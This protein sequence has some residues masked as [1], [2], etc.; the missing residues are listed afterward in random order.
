MEE[1]LTHLGKGSPLFSHD[2]IHDSQ[3]HLAAP[4][5]FY[6]Q[7]RRQ[8]ALSVRS[9]ISFSLVKVV[10]DK[11]S[12]EG[13]SATIGAEDILRFS[14]ELKSLTRTEDCIGRLGINECLIIISDGKSAA[15]RLISRLLTAQS[16]SVNHTLRISISAVTSHSGENGL[17]LLNRLDLQPLSTH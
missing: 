6:E 3:T 4:S 16:L 10:F 7:L 11:S 5:F 15:E 14:C 2:G 13:V 1:R 12:G 17:S 8:I 9:R